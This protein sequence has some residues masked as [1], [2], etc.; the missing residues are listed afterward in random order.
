MLLGAKG[1]EV[2]SLYADADEDEEMKS[3]DSGVGNEYV[4]LE[5]SGKVGEEG[6]EDAPAALWDMI[7]ACVGISV[8]VATRELGGEVERRRS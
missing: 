1:V 6:E 8:G 7:V 3:G 2:G 5:E 4:W